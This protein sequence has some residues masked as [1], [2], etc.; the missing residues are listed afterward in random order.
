MSFLVETVPPPPPAQSWT[1]EL[2]AADVR[3]RGVEVTTNHISHLR[4]GRRGNP[5]ARLLGA[6]AETFGVPV[7]YFFNQERADR[8]QEQLSSLSVLRDAKVQGG[9]EEAALV[10][11][12][13][14]AL[15]RL[16][17]DYGVDAE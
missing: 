6:I 5:S 3:R 15:R 16:Q 13:I 8:I 12:V 4:A 1:N 10:A 14:R 9:L 2:I 17:Q 11:E 7:D